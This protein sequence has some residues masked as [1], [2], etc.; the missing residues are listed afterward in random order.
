LKDFSDKKKCS[1]LPVFSDFFTFF[2]TQELISAYRRHKHKEKR[3][4]FDLRMLLP[5]QIQLLGF[6]NPPK[7]Q[8]PLL[9]LNHYHIIIIT[10][11]S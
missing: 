7:N 5:I 8:L 10:F 1:D 4:F 6:E 2:G 3:L 11:M 9:S